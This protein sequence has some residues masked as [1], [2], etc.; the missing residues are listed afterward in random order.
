MHRCYQNSTTLQERIFDSEEHLIVALG[1]YLL[2]IKSRGRKYLS[3]LFTYYALMIVSF[4]FGWMETESY[5]VCMSFSVLIG[6]QLKNL[7]EWEEDC[8]NFF[9]FVENRKETISKL[10]S[11]SLSPISI[12]TRCLARNLRPRKLAI[13]HSLTCL[14]LSMLEIFV[15]NN[16][17]CG[18][19]ETRMQ[20]CILNPRE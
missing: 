6:L 10:T 14:V 19:R 16:F 15:S 7:I 17:R 20:F 4:R 3:F 2:K 8:H 12:F 13:N 18:N 1:K 11:Q 5:F 9:F